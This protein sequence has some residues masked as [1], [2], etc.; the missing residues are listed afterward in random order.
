M[1]TPSTEMSLMGHPFPPAGRFEA[2]V[3]SA[4]TAKSTCDDE[5][6]PFITASAAEQ[7]GWE[8]RAAVGH[9]ESHLV[10]NCALHREMGHLTEPLEPAQ[11]IFFLIHNEL[12]PIKKQR[13]L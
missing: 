2:G 12:F 9:E 7:C 11:S 4:A 8:K 5:S 10:K 1:G 3:I 13:I 6:V